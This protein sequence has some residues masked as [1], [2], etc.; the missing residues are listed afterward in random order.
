MQ[1]KG[2]YRARSKTVKIILGAVALLCGSMIYLVF[3]SKSLYIYV[4]CKSVG[5]A[6]VVDLLRTA[7][8]DWQVPDFVVF[9]LPDGLYCA[10]WLL[11]IDAIWQ[12]DGRRIKFLFLSLV[13]VVT[14]G[15]EILQSWGWVRGTFDVVDFWCYAVPP[16]AYIGLYFYK[17]Y[18]TNFKL[19]NL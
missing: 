13:P 17:H 7:V 6:P 2:N 5:G 16:L 15:S 18:Y 1:H 19:E 9:S 8:Q 14:M 3:R 10:A 11:L 4:W 12:G